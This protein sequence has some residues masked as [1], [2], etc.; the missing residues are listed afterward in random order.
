MN[1]RKLSSESDDSDLV[2]L[3]SFLLPEVQKIVNDRR[4]SE[5]SPIRPL[6]EDILRHDGIIPVLREFSQAAQYPSVRRAHP[7]GVPDTEFSRTLVSTSNKSTEEDGKTVRDYLRNKP[8]NNR[9]HYPVI[10]AASRL[11]SKYTGAAVVPPPR[12]IKSVLNTSKRPISS[13]S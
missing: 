11:P 2:K 10:Q 4:V 7:S 9:S 13:T 5:N 1:K 6:L 8:A 3:C 12:S